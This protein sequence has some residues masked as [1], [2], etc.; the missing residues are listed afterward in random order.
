MLASTFTLYHEHVLHIPKVQLGSIQAYATLAM[1][2]TKFFSGIIVDI[3][4]N[5]KVVLIIG[6][7]LTMVT[8]VLF[9][10]VTAPFSIFILRSAERLT[11]GLRAVPTD[12]FL[13]INADKTSVGHVIAKK[14]AYYTA[15]GIAGAC[16]AAIFLYVYPTGFTTL[17]ILTV[18]P[19]ILA[20]RAVPPFAPFTA[21]SIPLMIGR[22][23][24]ES[25][26]T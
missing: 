2:G 20:I 26:G 5:Y 21:S 12:A 4:K 15:G 3:F 24:D 8:R 25:M 10:F 1:Y 6:S 14:Q 23:L 18:I 11:K 13:T 9:A 19:G 22:K 7:I 16:I 17:Y